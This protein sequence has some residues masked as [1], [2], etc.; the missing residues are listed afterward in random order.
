M[1]HRGQALT[2][3]RPK[4]ELANET[5]ASPERRRRGSTTQEA[6]MSKHWRM[7]VGATL[8]VTNLAGMTTVALAHTDNQHAGPSRVLA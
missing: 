6:T 8:A 5:V 4:G 3:Q 1:D 7:L 2:Q